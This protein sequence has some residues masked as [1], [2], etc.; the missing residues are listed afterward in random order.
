MIGRAEDMHAIMDAERAA[1]LIYLDD[2]T[3][4]IGGRRGRAAERTS[5]DGLIYATTRHAT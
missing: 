5:T 4:R 3:C 1:T 2:L